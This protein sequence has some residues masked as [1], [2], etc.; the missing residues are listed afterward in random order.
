M[1]FMRVAM[2]VMRVVM[3]VAMT[4][5]RVPTSSTR[6]AT[7]RSN[8]HGVRGG[9]NG[10]VARTDPAGLPVAVILVEVGVRVVRA[11]MRVAVAGAH[12]A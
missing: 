7:Y 6:C 10:G 12:K 9:I 11:A 4:V 1:A 3:R 5:M 2:A 8:P